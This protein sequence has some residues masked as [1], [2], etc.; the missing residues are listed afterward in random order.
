MKG[1]IASLVVALET[2]GRLGFRPEGDVVF[3]TVTDEESSGA[4][5]LAAVKRGVRADAGVCAE[6]TG[7]DLWTACRGSVICDVDVP[8]RAGHAECRQPHWTEGGAV[9]AIDKAALLLAALR[10]LGEEW[11]NRADHRHRLL[12]PGDVVPVAISGGEWEA[13]VPST[14][15]ITANVQFLPG[16]VDRAGSIDAA[17]EEVEGV[18]NAASAADSWLAAHPPRFHW[19]PYVLPAEVDETDPLVSLIVACAAKVGR[20]ARVLGLDSWHDPA[21]FIRFAGVPTVSFGPGELSSSHIIDEWLDL[22][23]LVEHCS[24]VALAIL[25]FCG[26]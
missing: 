21:N 20:Q 1:G 2:L 7:F 9:N 14:C 5:S 3:C 13:T 17:R 10:S 19:H 15:R 16:H 18:L 22:E 8:G 12:P 23:A 26:Q 4:G 6:N 25:H 11:R 24:V